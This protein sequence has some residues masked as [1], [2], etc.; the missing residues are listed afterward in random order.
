MLF[1][2]SAPYLAHFMRGYKFN[3]RLMAT[4]A[5]APERVQAVVRRHAE[6]FLDEGALQ[7]WSAIDPAHAK[8][9][10]MANTHLDRAGLWRLLWV[11][12]T[13]PY[14]PSE[15][16]YADAVGVTKSLMFSA[17]NV[18]PDV[19]SAVL[20]Y[21]A[22]RRMAE[23]RLEGY[24]NPDAQQR[25]L[26]R[27]TQAADGRRSRHRLLLLLLP[28]LSLA[29]DAHPLGA[30]L[31]EDRRR[32]VRERVKALLSD[33]PDPPDGPIDDRWEWAIPLLL[34]PGLRGFLEQWRMGGTVRVARLGSP[35]QA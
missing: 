20:S 11:P 26:L 24:D 21:E 13:V 19:V 4:I 5:H 22:E 7:T 16:A 17:W 12:P 32:W 31:G 2:K 35:R 8:L 28:C 6:S 1:W 18:V 29:N 3:E 34:D 14:W 15:G 33:L 25:P 30:P 23:G 27:F 10:E 9:R